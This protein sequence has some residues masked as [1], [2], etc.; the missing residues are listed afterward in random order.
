MDADFLVAVVS[1]WIHV[2]T[3]IVL[4]GGTSFMKLVVGPSLQGQPSELMDAIR[5]R[6]KKFVHGGIALFLI[7]GFFNYFRAMPDHKGDGLYHALIGTKII[8]A[9]V[10]FFFASVLV[11]R[12]AGTQKFRDN[13]GKWMSVVLLLSALIVAMSGVVKVR[14]IPS[15]TKTPAAE[16]AQVPAATAE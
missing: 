3:A 7:T 10:V 11:G 15:A 12:S 1:R 13:A 16:T 2:G 14:G 6:W 8:L 4:V 9:F 5:G